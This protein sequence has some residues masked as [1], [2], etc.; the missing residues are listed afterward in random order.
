MWSGPYLLFRTYATRPLPHSL[1][2]SWSSGQFLNMLRMFLPWELGI[3]YSL[4]LEYSSCKHANGLLPH[5]IQSLPS[6]VPLMR[7][8]CHS[9]CDSPVVSPSVLLP[10]FIFFSVYHCLAWMVQ[11]NLSSVSLSAS[12]PCKC[13]NFAFVFPAICLMPNTQQIFIKRINKCCNKIRVQHNL[14]NPVPG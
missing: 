12:K 2:S 5:F 3:F 13:T 1:H 10:C 4:C 11:I 7:L 8:P 9:T 14:S 6:C